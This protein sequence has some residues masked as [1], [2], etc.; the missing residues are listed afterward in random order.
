MEKQQFFLNDLN[1]EN[2]DIFEYLGNL[3]SSKCA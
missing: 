2:N 1:M 3:Y